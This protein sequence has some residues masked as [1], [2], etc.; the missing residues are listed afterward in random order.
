MLFIIRCINTNFQG[1]IHVHNVILYL[2]LSHILTQ[3]PEQNT[4]IEF[5]PT[6][7]HATATGDPVDFRYN[8]SEAFGPIDVKLETPFSVT[9]VILTSEYMMNTDI[10]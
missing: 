10:T 7:V 9:E 5:I 8:S 3:L 1:V 2:H 6:I 4:S